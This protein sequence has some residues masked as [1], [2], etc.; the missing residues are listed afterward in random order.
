MI[1]RQDARA[2]PPIDDFIQDALVAVLGI[3]DGRE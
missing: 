3:D 2:F 1:V